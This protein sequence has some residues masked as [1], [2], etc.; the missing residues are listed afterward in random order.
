LG[1][2]VELEIMS[3]TADFIKQILFLAYG[4]SSIAKTLNETSSHEVD[5]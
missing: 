5:A 1:I 2:T 4:G 3:Q